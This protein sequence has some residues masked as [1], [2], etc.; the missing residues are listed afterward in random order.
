[1]Y[2]FNKYLEVIHS[3]FLCLWQINKEHNESWC[4]EVL[5][6]T[7]AFTVDY[8]DVGLFGI[9]PV[10]IVCFG[11]W[12]GTDISSAVPKISP[13]SAYIGLIFFLPGRKYSGNLQNFPHMQDSSFV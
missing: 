9:L 11:I 3:F 5:D 8:S 1:M 7:L 2:K 4:Q 13:I 12:K 6:F 10:S